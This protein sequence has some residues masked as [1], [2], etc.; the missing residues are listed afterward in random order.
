M[1]VDTRDVEHN[2]DGLPPVSEQEVRAICSELEELVNRFCRGRGQSE[3][4]TP[5]QPLVS[6]GWHPSVA[7]ASQGK[8]A[9]TLLRW[10]R[11]PLRSRR[12]SR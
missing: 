12:Y 10:S 3:T 1:Q 9:S 2:V 5:D 7:R 4:L 8:M 6:L 11:S